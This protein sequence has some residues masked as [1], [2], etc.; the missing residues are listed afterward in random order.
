[1]RVADKIEAVFWDIDNT[2]IDSAAVLD[3][4]RNSAVLAMIHNGLP[5]KGVVDGLCRLNMLSGYFNPTWYSSLLALLCIECG[6]RDGEERERLIS[7]GVKAYR[8]ELE[9]IQ[10]LPG[11]KETIERLKAAGLRLGVISNCLAH[12]QMS[13][14]SKVGLLDYFDSNLLL[15]SSSAV[16]HSQT[17]QQDRRD[18]GGLLAYY[19]GASLYR[20]EKPWLTMFKEAVN[21]TGRSPQELL[22]VGDMLTDVIGANVAGF[23]SV[24][25]R[26]F[27]RDKTTERRTTGLNLERPDYVINRVSELLQIIGLEPV[28]E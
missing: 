9:T 1:M 5:V 23:T 13:N 24:L 12:I 11:A 18:F 21:R 15:I 25:L 22:F 19:E 20:T 6:I 26:S 16:D 3:R 27:D 7:S 10:M 17:Y 8:T 28:G 2:L 4:A 14:L